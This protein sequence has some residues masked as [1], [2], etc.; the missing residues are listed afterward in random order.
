VLL[1]FP[2]V[3]EKIVSPL[4][5]DHPMIGAI[6][7]NNFLGIAVDVTPRSWLKSIFEPI[8]FTIFFSLFLY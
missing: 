4:G 1:P 6:I 3:G 5:H 8:S 7:S 2:S